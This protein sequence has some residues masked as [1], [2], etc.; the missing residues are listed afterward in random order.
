MPRRISITI[1]PNARSA[2]ITALSAVEYRATVREPAHDGQA[3][4]ALLKLL[5]HY[6][7]VP[8]SKI[9]IVHGHTSRRKI[10]DLP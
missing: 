2:Q 5:S 10:V 6:F 1:K 8:K 4:E 3:N 7:G 9:R